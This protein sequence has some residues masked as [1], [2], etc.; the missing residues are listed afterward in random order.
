MGLMKKLTKLLVLVLVVAAV[1]GIATMIKAKQAQRDV[2]I[3]EWPD[4]P[5]NPAE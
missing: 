1:A 2:T 4:V 5:R 3:D